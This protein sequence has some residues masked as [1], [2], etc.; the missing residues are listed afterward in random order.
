[1]TDFTNEILCKC[2]TQ[3]RIICEIIKYI[4]VILFGLANMF[5]VEQV[6]IEIWGKH[7]YGFDLGE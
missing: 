4:S 3:S 7:L 5:G 2:N 1:M 6:S